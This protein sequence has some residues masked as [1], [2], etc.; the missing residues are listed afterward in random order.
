[1]PGTSSPTSA[2]YAAIFRVSDGP[3]GSGRLC[4]D[5]DSFS[6]DGQR[7]GE[8]FA[9]RVRFADVADVH[10][11]RAREERLTGQPTI[12][13]TRTGEPVLFVEPFGV[14]LLSELADLL[15]TLAARQPDDLEQVEVR[16][17]LKPGCL[18]RARELIDRGPPF[19]PAALHLQQ[20][21]VLMR[22]GEVV[23]VLRGPHVHETLERAMREPGFWRS[24]LAWKGC[25]SGRP[26]VAHVPTSDFVDY[27]LVYSWRSDS[28]SA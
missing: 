19:E 7:A 23:F 25:V 3:T 14:G 1:M 21:D 11:G 20:H 2:E 17:P 5:D 15:S 26:R 8:S 28:A 27:E 12:V 13:I 18:E 22:E 4:I 9:L 10:V 24:G 16:V 6:L